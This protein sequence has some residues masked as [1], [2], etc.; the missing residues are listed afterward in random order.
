MFNKLLTMII[1]FALSFAMNNN[2]TEEQREEVRN[3]VIEE[4]AKKIFASA[5]EAKRSMMVEQT[6]EQSLLD[7]FAALCS[8][9][10]RPIDDHRGAAA[11]RRHA[12]RVLSRLAAS[13]VFSEEIS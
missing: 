3:K 8:S 9:A 10:A 12:I 13:R 4:F 7:N 11:Y 1:I 6:R 5:M 2:L